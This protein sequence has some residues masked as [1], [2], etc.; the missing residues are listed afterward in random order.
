MP[1]RCRG[2]R[3][4]SERGSTSIWAALAAMAAVATVI[5][6]LTGYQLPIATRTNSPG[7]GTL[8]KQPVTTPTHRSVPQH[9]PSIPKATSPAGNGAAVSGQGVV[10]QSG[11]SATSPAPAPQP[12]LAPP[13]VTTPPTQATSSGN[14]IV[15]HGSNSQ[16]ATSG[17]ASCT[18]STT[19]GSVSSGNATNSNSSSTNI[20]IGGG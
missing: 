7:P 1:A 12:T 10:V 6:M 13:P 16:S 15:V 3:S 18:G 2:S 8:T 19:C 20:S 9:L 11:T 4:R 17:N 14:T 5:L